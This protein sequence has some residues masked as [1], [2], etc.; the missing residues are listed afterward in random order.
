MQ[1]HGMVPASAAIDDRPVFNFTRP[2]QQHR[3]TIGIEG[4]SRPSGEFDRPGKDRLVRAVGDALAIG[5]ARVASPGLAN[6]DQPLPD[7]SEDGDLLGQLRGYDTEVW[8]RG[9]VNVTGAVDTFDLSDHAEL[10][11]R[12]DRGIV[13]IAP[14]RFRQA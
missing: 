9:T 1:V 2:R 8:I 7:R 12:T 13:G 6:L 10:K 3:N 4:V 14:Q 5:P 11:D